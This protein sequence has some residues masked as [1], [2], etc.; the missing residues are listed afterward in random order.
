MTEILRWAATN[1]SVKSYETLMIVIMLREGFARECQF[2][3]LPAPSA[4]LAKGL[5]TLVRGIGGPPSKK[6]GKNR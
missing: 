6:K 5:Q 1:G 4:S 2:D 3:S